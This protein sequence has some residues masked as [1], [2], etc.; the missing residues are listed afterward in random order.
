MKRAAKAVRRPGV[1]P[2]VGIIVEG[3]AEFAALPLLHRKKLLPGCPP[4]KAVNLGGVGSDRKP[5]GIAKRVA[6]K[7][8]QLH[9]A[10]C[11]RIV[12]CFDRE[13]RPECAPGLAQAVARE[14]DAELAARG[15]QIPGVHVVIADRAFEAWLLADAVGLHQRG[16]FKHSPTFHTFE[17]HLGA[18]GRKGV[19][20]LTR[21]LGREYSKTKDGPALFEKLCFSD[22]RAHHPGARG[23]RSLDKLLRTLGV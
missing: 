12:V 17:G 2:T 1:L 18:Q 14:L 3:D 16:S 10:R 20:E 13:Q 11:E 8:I 4:L 19:V 5:I 6:P 7:V 21:L 15:K 23:S 22:A 9:L